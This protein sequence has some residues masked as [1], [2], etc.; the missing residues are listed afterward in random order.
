MAY[1]G[2]VFLSQKV[3]MVVMTLQGTSV[4]DRQGLIA[5]FLWLVNEHSTVEYKE[6]E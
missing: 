6:P 5:G 3:G 4:L 2:R 1:S